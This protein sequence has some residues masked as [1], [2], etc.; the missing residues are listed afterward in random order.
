MPNLGE[1]ADSYQPV[2]YG[3]Q[4][5]LPKLGKNHGCCWPGDARDQGINSCDTDYIRSVGVYL[6]LG[7]ILAICVISVWRINTEYKHVHYF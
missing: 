6:P 1:A 3:N 4:I 7:M 2:L 5:I